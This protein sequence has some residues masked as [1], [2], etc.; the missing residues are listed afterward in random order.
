MQFEPQL[1]LYPQLQDIL[2]D[3]VS[4]AVEDE[5][6]DWDGEQWAMHMLGLCTSIYRRASVLEKALLRVCTRCICLE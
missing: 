1:Q 2:R 4:A 6:L 3:A 5:R